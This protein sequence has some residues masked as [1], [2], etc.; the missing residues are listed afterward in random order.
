MEENRARPLP[1]SF[2]DPSG[3][4]FTHEGVIYRQVNVS[5]KQYYDE[6]M[7]SG[8]YDSLVGKGWLIPH[9]E[10]S[11][12]EHEKDAALLTLEIQMEALL[13]GMNPPHTT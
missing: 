6:L 13:H 11:L 7:E 4:L 8:L 2:R 3:F 10:V 1:S 12:P 9:Q 5:Y